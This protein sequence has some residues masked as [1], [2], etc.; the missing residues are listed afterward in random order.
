MKINA[1]D[2]IIAIL[3]KTKQLWKQRQI[4]L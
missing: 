2:T 3:L 1:V 4:T